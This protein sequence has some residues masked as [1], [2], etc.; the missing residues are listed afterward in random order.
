MPTVR[1]GG[2]TPDVSV[3]F[4]THDRAARLEALLASLR[5]QEFGGSFEVIVVDDGSRD[6]TPAVL[7]AELARGELRLRVI[8]RERARGPAS[9]RNAGWRAA[10]AP[11]VAFTDDDC[12]AS[13][14]WL[15]A[16]VRALREH[17]GS[18]AQGRT[19]PLPEELHLM[20]PFS[21]T[22][23]VH[24]AG[25]FFQTC[26]VFYP[27]ALLER[28]GG[29]D[30]ETFT[31]PGGE[32][33]DLAWRAMELGAAP[34][35]A[36]DAL[37]HHA[38]SRLGPVGKLR[39]AWRWS[40]TMRIFARHQGLREEL[41]HG[42]FWKGSHYLLARA[43]L[44]AALPRRL[45]FAGSWLAGPYLL[46]LLE[47]GRVEGGGPLAAP[48]FVLHDLVEMAAAARGALRYRTLVL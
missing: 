1:P 46:H 12:T 29:F 6:G 36:A 42:V 3:V 9:A 17:A 23:Q 22:L 39:V 19:D 43:L 31:V 25:P 11:L 5:A 45:R 33:A 38:V 30:E 32:D 48:Y 20:G 16:G 26:N 35:F 18:F 47:R 15:D 41:T 10:S 34:V 4:A 27:R 28:L 37:I 8:R 40:E 44:A 24:R 13:P 14:R 7:A 2:A 21:R